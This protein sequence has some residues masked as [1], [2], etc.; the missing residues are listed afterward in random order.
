MKI[1]FFTA[2]LVLGLGFQSAEAKNHRESDI[3]RDEISN[4]KRSI[5]SYDGTENSKKLMISHYHARIQL[6]S[7]FCSTKST[8][9]I[10]EKYQAALSR[11]R[12]SESESTYVY[13]PRETVEFN[14]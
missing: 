11:D 10:K 9:K 3:C 8:S 6:I 7:Q 5:K 4:L 1:G 12:S 13:A 14:Y 2:L